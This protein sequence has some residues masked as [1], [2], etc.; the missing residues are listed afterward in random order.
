MLKSL[1]VIGFK[2]FADK[3]SFAFSPG[4]TGVVGPNG[5]GKSN[6]VDAV[7]W[8]LGNQSAKSL[9]GKEMTD[10]IFNG[11]SGRKGSGF[12]EAN[13][14]FDNSTGFLAMEQQE[15]RIG[16]RIW[17]SGDSE[18]LINNQT[19]R[20][21]DIKDLLA[22]SGIGASAYCI[23]EQGRVDQILQSNP[24][25]RRTVFEEAAGISRFRGRKA[26]AERKLDRVDQNLQRLTDIVDE[27]EARLIST[28][29][30][31]A[32]AAKYREISEELRE[33]WLGL[34]AD[35]YRRFSAQHT[36]L[37]EELKQQQ[38]AQQ[39]ITESQGL[40]D[41]QLRDLDRDISQ[42]DD[43]LRDVERQ[44]GQFRQ[45]ITAHRT[46]IRHQTARRQEMD[47]EMIRLRR[48]RQI[49]SSRFNE[50]QQETE[51]TKHVLSEQSRDYE[52]LKL[53]IQQKQ[54]SVESLIQSLKSCRAEVEQLRQQLLAQTRLQAEAKSRLD[55]IADQKLHLEATIRRKQREETELTAE[56]EQFEE[57]LLQQHAEVRD[58][59]ENVRLAEERSNALLQQ[60][61]E[62]R[63][64]QS[65]MKQTI[66]RWRE[67]RSAVRARIALLEDFESRQEG[68]GIGAQDILERARTTDLPPWNRIRGSVADVLQVD[69][70]YAPLIELALGN[71][72]E[73][74]LIDQLQPLID[75]LANSKTPVKGRVGFHPLPSCESEQTS[76]DSPDLSNE[77]GVVAR[78]DRL[79]QSNTQTETLAAQLLDN[80]WVVES[81][82]V[83]LQLVRKNDSDH[84]LRFVTLQGELLESDGTLFVGTV[85]RETALLPRR[86]ELR[87]LKLDLIRLDDRIEGDEKRILQG[88]NELTELQNQIEQS[89][90][91]LQAS[92][93]ELNAVKNQ[94]AGSE[95]E[96]NRRQQLLEQ[97]Q[98][99]LTSATEQIGQLET[100][101]AGVEAEREVLNG[102]LTELQT[103]I[104]R[105]EEVELQA[106]EQ[107]HEHDQRLASDK[108]ELAKQ[109][110]RVISLKQSYERL[111]QDLDLREQQLSDSTRRLEQIVSAEREATL[112]IL[113]VEAELA[114]LHLEEEDLSLRADALLIAKD[115]ARL[116]RGRLRH[117][118]NTLR[119]KRRTVEE[120]LHKLEIQLRDIN[121][122]IQA[123]AERIEEEYQLV[124]Q[125]VV[126]S[127]ASAIRVYLDDYQS[128]REETSTEADSEVTGEE[129][130]P[131]SSQNN[132]VSSTNPPELVFPEGLD[133][134]AIHEELDNRVNRLRRKRK[135]MG[136]VDTDTLADLDEL[137]QRFNLLN[138]QLEDLVEARNS[139]EE[140]IRKIN[141]ESKRLFAES[142]ETIRDH[143]RDLFRKL[144]GGGEGDIILEDPN[145]ILEC[146]VDIVARPPGKELRSISLLSGGEKTMTAVAMLMAIF[147]SRPSPFCIL[148]EVDAALDEANIDRFITVLKEFQDSTQFIII[149]HR[150]P[151]MTVCDL[152][153][154]VTME[155][156]GVSKRMSVKFDEVNDQGEFRTTAG[157]D[158]DAA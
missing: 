64:R 36:T 47:T 79:V 2:S 111:V 50:A 55:N 30:Q 74:I 21:R 145:D 101:A 43:Q 136:N 153:Y 90:S 151:T 128:E 37:S 127:G 42:I 148:D 76:S 126:D 22:G 28:R 6:V 106:E 38:L 144:F 26:E 9:R 119:G 71:R 93:D 154:G 89:R 68:L 84:S 112:T 100:D 152:L 87:R 139:L 24:A 56:I 125:D 132:D 102:S 14:L 113:N 134:D 95:G 45:K 156:S 44:A 150:K 120:Q 3:T 72:A 63:R 157:N 123:L 16:R 57:K 103:E 29:S 105:L 13:L 138:T 81:L 5:S 121:Y 86:S 147:K 19:A 11:S 34:S 91:A 135:M 65:E 49:A 18:Y 131:V 8:I 62:L 46:T 118:E 54:N 142:F 149:T 69:L 77:T 17:N 88:E 25:N 155:Q 109:E 96:L 66:N 110:E 27:L 31:A 48:Q 115:D 23:I 137:E 97:L 75:Y 158:A 39:E 117:Q 12:A 82:Q 1:E 52:T 143:F 59:A 20:L 70:E 4:I 85:S 80:T 83:A 108:L 15:I 33:L 32:K 10:V 7:K 58:A 35:E 140:I 133:Y 61:D 98:Q 130:E 60:R 122:Q 107:L 146:G 116:Q 73:L 104:S 129:S 51:R 99:D 67:E 78:A 114:E 92:R 124:I 40:I 41:S 53:T 141:T 94:V